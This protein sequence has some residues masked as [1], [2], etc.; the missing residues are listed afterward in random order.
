M[1]L[2]IA[3]AVPHKFCHESIEDLGSPI[4]FTGRNFLQQWGLDW[5]ERE[6]GAAGRESPIMEQ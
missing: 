3:D 6:R 1:V 4:L 2:F 5:R